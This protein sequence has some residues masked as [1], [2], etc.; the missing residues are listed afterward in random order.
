[1]S[2]LFR[3]VPLQSASFALIIALLSSAVVAA[4]GPSAPNP[5]APLNG[6]QVTVPFTISWSA[7]SDPSGIIAYNWQISPASSFSPV[8]RQDSTSGQTQATISGLANGTYFWRVQAVNG[9][10]QQGA[11][12]TTASFTVSGVGPGEPGTASLRLGVSGITQFHPFESIPFAWD[13]VPGA[14]S[15]VFEADKSSSFPVGSR[16]H[17]DNIPDTRTSIVIADFCNGCEQG[18]YFAHVFAVDANGN[19]GVPSAAVSF[20]VFYTAPLPPA[21]T[22]LTPAA[23]A[24]IT[25]PVT[26]TWTDVPNPQL[27]GYVLE[28]A[29]DPGFSTIDYGNNQITGPHWTVTSLTAGT[30]YWHVLSTQGNSGPSTAANTAWSTTRSF[31]VP[32]TPAAASLDLSIAAPFSGD[33]ET[34]TVQLTGP[35]PTGGAV[36]NLTSSNPAAAPVPSTFNMPAG[37]AF[38]QF[39][40]QT[41]QVTSDTPVTL[42]ASINGTSAAT[43]FTVQPPSLKSVWTSSSFTGGLPAQGIVSLNGLA[44]SGGALVALTSTSPAVNPPPSVTVAPGDPTVMFSIPTNAVTTTTTATLTATWQGKSAQT[45]I[46]L[47][48]QQ[49]PQS[50]TLSPTTT[51]GSSGSFATVSLAS[52]PTSDLALPIASSD[53]SIARINSFVTIPAG[54]TRGG[55]DI[56]T[57]LVNT[58]TNVVISVSGAG[59]TQSATLTVNPSGTPPPPP[60]GPSLTAVSLNP[61]TVPAGSSSQGMVTFS[62]AVSAATSVSLNSANTAASVPASVTVPAGSASATFPV[63]TT[64]VSGT[65]SF[66]INASFGGVLQS[67]ALT[68][69]QQP[70]AASTLSTV[71]LS[72]TT[73]TGGG[74]SQ[75]VVSLSAAADSGGAVV[76]LSSNST[77]ATVPASVTVAAGAT[78]A[79]FMVT[80]TAVTTTTSV[81]I[82][83][84]F[85]GT[86]R[87]A[88]LTVTSA[89]ATATDKVSI[90]QAQYTVKSKVLNVRATSSNSSATLSAYDT[91]G[92]LIGKLANKGGGSYEG[93]LSWPSNPGTVSVRSSLGGSA[94]S[95]VTLK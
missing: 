13:P 79:T 46:T 57:T 4:A 15:Y 12:S 38:G 72:P 60:A 56:F 19:R 27:S 39:R 42:T 74:S 92:A 75:G 32:S 36:V 41:G 17:F 25:L 26:M 40:L 54:T 71:S 86:T 65:T 31:V 59:V 87:T 90:Q 18:N 44:A 50:L 51:S 33:T 80:T 5:T 94:A 81:T 24:Q 1:M 89:T 8:T 20:G 91:S 9:A 37:F 21:P 45:Q 22:P 49:A 34:V 52:A 11:W 93:Q 62:S 77:S 64:L 76:S 14:A 82:T 3:R 70:A 10:F 66:L 23:G 47:N 35:A 28:I 61:S 63:T 84:G 6:A 53:P 69:T 7:V 95:S 83:A 2:K 67:A 43:T 30:K 29:S 85:G 73:V 16:V 88:G 68:I 78:S 48:P 55:F 58:P